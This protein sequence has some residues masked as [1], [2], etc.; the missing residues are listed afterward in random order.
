MRTPSSTSTT[1][2]LG[3]QRRRSGVCARRGADQRCQCVGDDPV[4]HVLLQVHSW[5]EVEPVRH[6]GREVRRHGC[7]GLVESVGKGS[8]RVDDGIVGAGGYHGRRITG[9]ITVDGT[10]VGVIPRCRRQIRAAD[11]TGEGGV[12][13][14]AARGLFDERRPALETKVDHRPEQDHRIGPTH[15]IILAAQRQCCGEVRPGR[16]AGHRHEVGIAADPRG[17]VE[18]P[19]QNVVGI[20]ERY[21][22]RKLRSRPVI[23]RDHPCTI[24][25]GDLAGQEVAVVG[26]ADRES[27]T[28]L[29]DHH[30]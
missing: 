6:S 21:R 23:R 22:E 26:R 8:R 7:T 1:R 24:E 27:A 13:D 16:I 11:E 14:D 2:G 19:A 25:M 12:V 17:V 3:R 28:V 9:E 29:V 5:E 30:G 10:R 4:C 20:V 15:A 18:H